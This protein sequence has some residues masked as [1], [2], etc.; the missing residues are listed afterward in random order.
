MWAIG[1]TERTR[2]SAY[3]ATSTR[4]YVAHLGDPSS[5]SVDYRGYE[6]HYRVPRDVSAGYCVN[7]AHSDV[8]VPSDTGAGYGGYKTS[9]DVPG[10]VEYR[11]REKG[12]PGYRT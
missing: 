7:G 2:V 3:Q 4:A 5:I 12:V 11:F 9:C 10:G 6:T 1:L 8:S